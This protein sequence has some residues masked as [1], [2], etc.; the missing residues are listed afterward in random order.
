LF[1]KLFISKLKW[2]KNQNIHQMVIERF[3][4]LDNKRKI[5]EINLSENKYTDNL[6]SQQRPSIILFLY[7]FLFTIYRIQ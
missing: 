1:K 6:N 2:I 5:N 7:F 4:N 3:N